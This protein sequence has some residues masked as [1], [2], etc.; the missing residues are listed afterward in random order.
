MNFWVTKK[1]SV[2][3][4]LQNKILSPVFS[5]DRI[6]K[7]KADIQRQFPAIISNEDVHQ[8]CS[9]DSNSK[10]NWRKKTDT[11]SAYR[12]YF[13]STEFSRPKLT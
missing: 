11:A 2:F 1:N 5:S 12:P 13:P 4:G 6:F 7:A 3:G 10:N 8:V 9:L